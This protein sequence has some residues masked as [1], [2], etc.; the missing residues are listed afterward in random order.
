[1]KLR[2]VTEVLEDLVPTSLAES[3]DNVGLLLGDPEQDISRVLLA[4][5]A[6][7]AVIAEAES[8]RCELVVCY[9][10]MIFDG[11]KRVTAGS[12]VHRALR[13]GIAAWSPHSALDVVEGGTSDV[14]ADALCLAT[15]APL[16]RGE[17]ASRSCKLIVFTPEE[18]VERVSRAMFDAGAGVIGEYACCSFRSPGTG[19]FHGSDATHPAVGEK[20]RLEQVPELRVEVVAPLTRLPE[21]I[22]ALRASHPYEEPAFDLVPLMREPGAGLGRVGDLASPTPVHVL[23]ARVRAALSLRQL[24]VAG[25]RDAVV[26][27]AACGPGSCGDLW[28]E[29]HARGATFWLT[30]EMRH[31]EALA[32]AQA[33]MTVACTL[34][35]NSERA[36]LRPLAEKLAKRLPSLGVDVSTAD[37]DPFEIA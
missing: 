27:R 26:S 21:I 34:H 8:Q 28:R 1:M 22:A 18:D 6:T 10:P 30:G 37:R 2:E 17:G 25:P 23:L 11:L 20:G 4:I 5:D 35:S 16:R 19:T 14:L 32:A 24:I 29:A 7:D 15:R 12:P 33:G 3:W 36:A 13:A 9:H 31:H